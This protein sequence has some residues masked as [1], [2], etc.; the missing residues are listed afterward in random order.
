MKDHKFNIVNKE[1]RIPYYIQI[2]KQLLDAINNNIYKVGEQLE[3]EK[4]LADKFSVGRPTIRQA[5]SE[6][7]TEGLLERFKGKGTFIK[8]RRIESTFLQNFFLDEELRRK[9][10]DFKIIVLKKELVIASK[11]IKTIFKLNEKDKINYIESIRAINNTPLTLDLIYVPDKICK[12]L[13]DEDL[14]IYSGEEIVKVIS[15]K[16]NKH[17][18]RF[19][20]SI[21]PVNHISFSRAARLL[22]IDDNGCFFYLRSLAFDRFNTPLIYF[23]AFF[24]SDRIIFTFNSEW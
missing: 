12:N 1:N 19:T 24:P 7:E 15:T 13:I 8:K 14:N 10:I 22:K 5:I 2:K 23:E 3:S 6:L 4:E 16:S 17:I 9:N 18:D 20:R 21:E 11:E